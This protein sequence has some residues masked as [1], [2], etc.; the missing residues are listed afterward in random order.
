M[1]LLVT[2]QYG[3]FIGGLG[4]FWASKSRSC[5]RIIHT[6]R[7]YVSYGYL[8]GLNSV[9]TGVQRRW[10]RDG[11]AGP[12]LPNFGVWRDTWRDIKKRNEAVRS[13]IWSDKFR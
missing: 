4:N 1:V 6:T 3:V 5:W 10:N 12:D 8:N 13:Y 9:Q 11:S 7:Y 2:G